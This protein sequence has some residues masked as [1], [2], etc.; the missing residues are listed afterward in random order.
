MFNISLTFKMNHKHVKIL[1]ACLLIAVLTLTGCFEPVDYPQIAGTPQSQSITPQQRIAG[2]SVQGRPLMYNVLGQGPDTILIMATIHGNE[3]AGTPLVRRL[4][5]YIENNPELL[6]SRTVILLPVA[7]PDGFESKS[8]YNANKVDL[9]RN[10]AAENRVNN[11]VNGPA[12]LSEPESKAIE[13]IIRQHSPNRI[14]SLHQMVGLN[15][16]DL[17]KQFPAGC[18]D[19][20]GPGEQ[21]ANLMAQYCDLPVKKLGSRP[22]SL[23]SYAGV[24]LGIPIITFEMKREDSNLDSQILW[25]RYGKALL[26]S[27][28]YPEPPESRKY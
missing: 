1:T 12:G 19:Y 15:Y 28:T 24:S 8:R 13:Q 9:N 26:A 11:K 23:G 10:F 2:Y 5:T 14:V 3:P 4:N 22:G 17:A 7:N 20:D 21:L 16:D 18:I 25:N 6:T 27:I